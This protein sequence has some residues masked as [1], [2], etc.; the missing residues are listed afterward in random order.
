[1][2][3]VLIGP[4]NLEADAVV[5]QCLDNQYVSDLVFS[6]MVERG[7]DYRDR[8]IAE[9]REKDFRTEF[10]RSLVY[11]SQV[12]IQRAFFK[13][14]EFLY[15]NYLPENGENLRAFA[16]LMREKA[17]VP[18]LFKESSLRDNLE[19]DVSKDGDRATRALLDEVGDE[20]T[21]VRLAVDDATNE[22]ATSSMATEFGVRMKRPDNMNDEQRNAMASELFADPQR[23]QEEGMWQAFDAAIDSLMDSSNAKS[24]QLRKSSNKLLTRQDVYRDNFI[25]EGKDDENVVLGRFKR[26]GPDNPF[27]L[28]LKKYVDLVYNTNLPDHLKRYT[29]TPANMPSRMALQDAPGEGYRHEQ[30]ST[31]VSDGDALESIR[32]TFMAHSQKAMS[33]PSLRH[34]KVADVL[35]L[36]GLPEWDSFKESQAQI[37][38]YP[39]QCL[40]RLEEF[41]RNFDQF[42]RALSDWYNRKYEWAHTEKKYCN[43]VSLALSL[44]G[45]LIVAGSDLGPYE[46]AFSMFASDRI[47]NNIPKKVKGYAAKLMVG[48][49]DIGKQRLDADRTYTIELMQ[50]NA[51]LMREDVVALLNSI[52]RKSGAD[53]PGASGQVADQGIQ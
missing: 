8:E 43:Y 33:L 50:T 3:A 37:L 9:L 32:R 25:V 40:D 35:E 42:Q 21:C 48:V 17:V 4:D 16:R 34:L 51:E 23:L 53:I 45:Q 11:S 30:L 47:T 19:F 5:P 41:Q 36:R 31:L 44:G 15:K 13:N 49:Y 7:V 38:K 22:R 6:K 39:L 12:I 28:E 29:F 20:V 26:P 1:M 27:L 52:N 10:I 14:S 2:N 24:R 46:M 18:Y